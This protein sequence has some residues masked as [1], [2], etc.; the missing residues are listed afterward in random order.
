M[1]GTF[2]HHPWVDVEDPREDTY[3]LFNK[4]AEA[5]NWSDSAVHPDRGGAR[6]SSPTRTAGI[7]G[8]NEAGGNWSDDVSRTAD[9]VLWVQTSLSQP[10]EQ[11][12]IPIAQLGLCA[13][14]ALQRVGALSLAG[15]Q[16]MMPLGFAPV[17]QP[18]T[19]GALA[20]SDPTAR[21]DVRIEVD[22]GEDD[23]CVR[24]AADIIKELNSSCEID[25]MAFSAPV[26]QHLSE[27]LLDEPA[28]MS[29]RI[30]IG[31]SEDRFETRVTVPEFS[32]D[33]SSYL[34]TQIAR[35]C[36]LAGVSNPVLITLRRADNLM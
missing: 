19:W 2:R 6:L 28:E 7:W 25:G 15:V 5:L 26:V 13:E 34:T 32:L 35:S 20:I 17:R 12:E 33:V 23:T 3:S 27:Y 8:M 21:A 4:Y 36:Q 18:H 24:Q 29:R 10:D 16:M 1:Y 11:A 14:K 22:G 31:D 9:H 30:W